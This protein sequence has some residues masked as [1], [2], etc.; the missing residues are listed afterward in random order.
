MGVV[1]V[2][3]DKR[4]N[5]KSFT[6]CLT[7]MQQPKFAFLRAK[8]P[9]LIWFGGFGRERELQQWKAQSALLI[10]ILGVH[11]ALFGRA[12]LSRCCQF[13]SYTSRAMA[14]REQNGNRKTLGGSGA[15]SNF[16]FYQPFCPICFLHQNIFPLSSPKLLDLPLSF[17]GYS[18]FILAYS[19]RWEGKDEKERWKQGEVDS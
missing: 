18:K 5:Y 10:A 19:K 16:F 17:A 9:S 7:E 2:Q 12:V 1:D 14:E 3:W 11:P 8:Q 13:L 4:E 6:G 15:V